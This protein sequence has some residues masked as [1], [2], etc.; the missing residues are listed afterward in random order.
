MCL[1]FL[2]RGTYFVEWLPRLLVASQRCKSRKRSS[3]S[4][5]MQGK[6]LHNA[7][8]YKLKGAPPEVQAFYKNFSAAYTQEKHEFVEKLI[9]NSCKDFKD[10]YWQDI[11]KVVKTSSATRRRNLNVGQNVLSIAGQQLWLRWP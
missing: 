3:V 10:Q 1:V 8:S 9:K 7:L 11:C 6:Q 2:H 5:G 4:M